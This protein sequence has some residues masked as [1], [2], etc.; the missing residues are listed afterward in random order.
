MLAALHPRVTVKIEPRSILS[1]QNRAIFKTIFSLYSRFSLH[2]GTKFEA[3]QAF[4]VSRYCWVVQKTR[5]MVEK[6][7]VNGDLSLALFCPDRIERGSILTVT[8]YIRAQL[9]Q[10]EAEQS[11]P[12]AYRSPTCSNGG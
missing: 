9:G 6:T 5:K 12:K 7:A 11:F 8:R 4:I 3:K 1:G 10:T 2:L